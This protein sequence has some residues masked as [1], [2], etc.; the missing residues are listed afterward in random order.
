MKRLFLICIIILSPRIVA[1][2][3]ESYYMEDNNAV[4][5]NHPKAKG[6]DFRIMVPKGWSVEDGDRPNVVCKL[7]S[8][9]NYFLVIVNNSPTFIS[10]NMAKEICESGELDEGA[11]EYLEE[12]YIDGKI[13]SV[14]N[15]VVDT[16]PSRLI[17][18]QYKVQ[19]PWVDK[20][21]DFKSYMWYIMY[22]DLMVCILASGPQQDFHK[23]SLRFHQIAQSLVFLDHYE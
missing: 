17:E 15:T 19:Y 6:L 8:G 1:W 2:G 22:E 13:L 18:M 5:C 10:R 16:Y 23:T 21:F 14:S 7:K 4:F 20:L 12:R 3:Q 11:L 9:Y